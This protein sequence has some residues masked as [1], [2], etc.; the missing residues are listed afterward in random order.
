M[1]KEGGVED[2]DATHGMIVTSASWELPYQL[3]STHS[4]C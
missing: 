3:P 4:A 1:G 2:K